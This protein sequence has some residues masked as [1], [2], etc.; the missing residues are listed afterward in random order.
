MN[1]TITFYDY[2]IGAAIWEIEGVASFHYFK[3]VSEITH[4]LR[5]TNKSVKQINCIKSMKFLSD[6]ILD[7]IK[8]EYFKKAKETGLRYFAFVIP[9]NDEGQSSM[10]IANIG[11]AEKWGIKIEYFTNKKDAVDWL[12]SK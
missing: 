9:N 6:E 7:F 3:T 1:T 4:V 12:V 8:D 10:E 11:A 5:T 2:E